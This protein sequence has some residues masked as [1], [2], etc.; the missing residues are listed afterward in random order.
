MY[1]RYIVRSLISSNAVNTLDLLKKLHVPEFFGSDEF[2]YVTPAFATL[3]RYCF[4]NQCISFC[5][6]PSNKNELT[7]VLR[8]PKS[9]SIENWA[10]IVQQNGCNFAIDSDCIV[11]RTLYDACDELELLTQQLD[12]KL[13]L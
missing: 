5:T 1:S 4:K 6:V 3:L 8:V 7:M 9:A 2:V 10:S 13:V 11:L 12:E